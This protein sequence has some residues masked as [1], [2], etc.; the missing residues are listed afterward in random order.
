MRIRLQFF[1]FKIEICECQSNIHDSVVIFIM[2][3]DQTPL[4][5]TSSRVL[6]INECCSLLAYG[7][8]IATEHLTGRS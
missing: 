7:L 4:Q 5:K 2:I 8:H 6:L 1:L 3:D